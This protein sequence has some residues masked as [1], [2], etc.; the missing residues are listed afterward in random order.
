MSFEAG[1]WLAGGLGALAGVAASRLSS[2]PLSGRAG[3]VDGMMG[4]AGGVVL[5]VLAYGVL[6]LLEGWAAF[7][8]RRASPVVPLLL[9]AA[10]LAG[11]VTTLWV[12][13]RRRRP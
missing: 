6:S 12:V 4:A 5:A 2:T 11:W 1:A 13:G 8:Q 7:F 10:M 3:W 9:T